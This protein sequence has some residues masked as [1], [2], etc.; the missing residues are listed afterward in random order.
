[1]TERHGFIRRAKKV[2][3]RFYHFSRAHLG[4][5]LQRVSL[6]QYKN[7]FSNTLTTTISP[8]PPFENTFFPLVRKRM[9]PSVLGSTRRKPPP[10]LTQRGKSANIFHSNPGISRERHNTSPTPPPPH[11]PTLDTNGRNDPQECNKPESRKN[12][13]ILNTP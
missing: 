4:I 1:M 9:L 12:V 10:V 5:L 11:H 2:E 6:S 8:P 13:S 3:I 7:T